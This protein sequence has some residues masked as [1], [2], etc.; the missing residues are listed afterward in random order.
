MA[1]RAGREYLANHYAL[2]QTRFTAHTAIALYYGAFLRA[3]VFGIMTL[4]IVV[5]VFVA[6]VLGFGERSSMM[7]WAGMG[8]VSTLLPLAFIAWFGVVTIYFRIQ[9]RNII[10]SALVLGGAARFRSNIS[11][12]RYQ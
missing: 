2:G 7:E 5:G 3:I 6:T 12:L 10:V 4:A 8:G 11:A 9:A 1:A